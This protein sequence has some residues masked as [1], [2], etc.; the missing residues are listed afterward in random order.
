[1]NLECWR[2]HITFGVY[3]SVEFFARGEVVGQLDTANF[4]HAVAIGGAQPRGFSVQDN[5]PES[6]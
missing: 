1:M 3:I 5:F 6:T 2:W 4:N